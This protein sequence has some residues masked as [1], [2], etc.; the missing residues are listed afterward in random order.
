MLL[1]NGIRPSL[2]AWCDVDVDIQSAFPTM[3]WEDI[4]EAMRVEVPS[5]S[6]WSEWCHDFVAPVNLPG[7]GTHAADRGA[8]QTRL[9]PYNAAPS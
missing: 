9:G 8:E 3:S 7:G 1:S 6:R 4:D 2:G 5:L